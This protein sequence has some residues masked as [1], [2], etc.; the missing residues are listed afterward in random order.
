MAQ[1]QCLVSRQ[2]G[3]EGVL[4]LPRARLRLLS[5]VRVL[6]VV[7]CESDPRGVI[8]LISVRRATRSERG[9]Y[10]AKWK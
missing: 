4:E 5:D 1:V 9:Q 2:A 10:A 8:R 6:V 7:H 3:F